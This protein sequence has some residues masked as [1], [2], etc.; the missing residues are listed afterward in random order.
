MVIEC[1]EGWMADGGSDLPIMKGE[2]FKGRLED[3]DI[4]WTSME[5]NLNPGMEFEF[6]GRQLKNFFKVKY[7]DK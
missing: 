5:G 2:R 7:Y 6:V 4:I 1:T 3:G